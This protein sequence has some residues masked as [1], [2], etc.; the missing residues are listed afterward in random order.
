MS[1]FVY[2]QIQ[3]L[4]YLAP[5]EDETLDI[6]II[7]YYHTIMSDEDQNTFVVLRARFRLSLTLLAVLKCNSVRSLEKHKHCCAHIFEH[8]V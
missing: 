1:L 5:H 8:E 2:C 3:G 4:T 6:I 7:N